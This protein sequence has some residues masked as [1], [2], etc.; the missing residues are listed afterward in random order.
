MLPALA[1]PSRLDSDID[2][3]SSVHA[4]EFFALSLSLSFP[5]SFV[6]ISSIQDAGGLL[7]LRLQLRGHPRSCLGGHR[8]LAA[9]DRPSSLSLF[10]IL[11]LFL[12]YKGLCLPPG[13]LLPLGHRC[14]QQLLRQKGY[15]SKSCG[16][17]TTPA[18]ARVE[19]CQRD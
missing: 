10:L 14:H 2:V 7:H 12:F 17:D 11:C 13:L 15:K 3:S 16:I 5:R 1:G 19:G 6:S 8:V 4:K 18:V 9:V